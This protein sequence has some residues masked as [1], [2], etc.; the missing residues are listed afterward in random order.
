[1]ADV[2]S[3]SGIW[4][5]S[6]KILG[7]WSVVVLRRECGHQRIPDQEAEVLFS[8]Y[9]NYLIGNFVTLIGSFGW[10]RKKK[11]F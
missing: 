6:G 3:L 1:M 5:L 10:E 8:G 4:S 7:F 9:I 11:R 2:M